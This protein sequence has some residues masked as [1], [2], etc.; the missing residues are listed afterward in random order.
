MATHDPN[1]LRR[2]AAQLRQLLDAKP[3]MPRRE[4]EAV[5]YAAGVLEKLAD[6]AAPS[7]SLTRH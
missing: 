2:N 3:F 1:D 4:R 5:A 7:E 6:E